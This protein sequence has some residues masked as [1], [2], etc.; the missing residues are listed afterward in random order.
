MESLVSSTGASTVCGACHM[1][2]QEMVGQAT[3]V[4]VSLVDV[5]PVAENIRTFRFAPIYGA[6]DPAEPGQYVFIKGCINGEWVQRPYTISSSASVTNYREVTVKR[7]A[8]GVFSNWLFNDTVERDTLFMSPPLGEYR[9]PANPLVCFVAGIGITPALAFMRS[10]RDEERPLYI[11]YSVRTPQ[12]IAYETELEELES[13]KQVRIQLSEVEGR[14]TYDDIAQIRQQFP[15]AS[16]FICGPTHYQEM[17]SSSLARL[18]VP[19]QSIHVELFVPP[20]LEK[21]HTSLKYFW[22]GLFLLAAFGVQYLAGFEWAWLEGV[23]SAESYKRWS[24]FALLAYLGAQF[25]LPAARWMGKYNRA[26]SLYRW[27]RWQGSAAPIVFYAHS[28]EFGYAAIAFLSA[29][30]FL[31]VIVGLFNQEL[32]TDVRFK[33]PYQRVWLV[34]HI[35]LSLLVIALALVH[36]YNVFA[37]Q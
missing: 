33:M 11:H 25:L 22:T 20:E 36:M 6:L 14:L 5:E 21:R 2:L 27:H 19:A 31:N 32:I 28:N 9:A 26:G 35:T 30:Y 4:P 17:V 13:P 16:Y 24:G 34:V 12:R 29:A 37:F 10:W 23:Q 1:H 3:W 7:L 18:G 8:D 15:S